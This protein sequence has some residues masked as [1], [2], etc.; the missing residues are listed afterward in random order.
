MKKRLMLMGLFI[1]M[2]ICAMPVYATNVKDSCDQISSSID[3]KLP[4]MVHTIILVIQ[5]AVPVLLV[6]FGMIDLFKGMIAQKEDEIKKGQQTFI[7]R[8]IAAIIV[9]FVIQIVQ[10]IIRFVSG[11]DQNVSGCFNCFINGQSDPS[12]CETV[13]VE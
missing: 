13:E 4:N 3:V 8:A 2:M 7:K 10:I 9:F 12:A 11:N 5:I 6:I 1:S